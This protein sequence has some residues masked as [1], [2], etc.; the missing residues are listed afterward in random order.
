MGVQKFVHN[1]IL[2]ESHFRVC[3]VHVPTMDILSPAVHVYKKSGGWEDQ[4]H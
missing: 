3:A 4:F 1:F 2:K